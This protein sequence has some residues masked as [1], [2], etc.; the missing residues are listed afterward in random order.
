[1]A[2]AVLLQSTWHAACT[3]AAGTIHL[4]KALAFSSHCNANQPNLHG[5]RMEMSIAHPASHTPGGDGHLESPLEGSS[6]YKE[7]DSSSLTITMP[8]SPDKKPDDPVLYPK[9]AQCRP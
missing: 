3:F 9:V 8:F 1:M 6:H 2:H 4:S 7:V 5:K